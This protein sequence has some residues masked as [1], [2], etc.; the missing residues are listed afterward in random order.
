VSVTILVVDD[1]PQV[2]DWL[3][4]E[5]GR[6]GYTTTGCSDARAAVELAVREDFDLVVADVEMPGLR[7]IDLMSE[8]QARKPGTLVLLITAFGMVDLAV[9]AVKAGACDFVTKPF[10]IEVLLLAIERALRDRRMRKEIVRLRRLTVD[11]APDGIVARSPAMRRV[12]ERAER[13]AR[14]TSSVLLTGET[15][16]GKS[17]VA[18]MLHARSPRRA[19]PFVQVN[20]AG[21]PATLVEGELFGVRRGAFTGA[22]RDRDGL[23]ARAHGGTLLLDE[24]GELPLESQPKL[25][26][27]LETGRIRPLG[28]A[29]DRT[30]DVRLVAATNRDLQGAV[31]ER[32]FR[33]DLLFRLDVV[34][35]EVPPLRERKEDLEGLVDQFVERMSAR[36]GRAVLGVA[37]D[38]MA[39]LRAHSWPGNV[40]EL[41]NLVEQ[42]VALGEHDV[43][44]LDDVR[45]ESSD[46]AAPED[47]PLETAIASRTPLEAIEL[48]YIRRT[49]EACG[50][51]VSEA[52]RRLGID[53]RTLYRR[54]QEP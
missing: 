38:A 34:R 43:I 39:W 23:F 41:Q 26:D 52:A 27:V 46:P 5:L 51:N 6:E 21:I 47:D 35:I 16:V 30:V 49:L 42:A 22:D 33:A 14:V 37:E 4:D 9:R 50:G 45:R 28:G 29:P 12:L 3:R 25:L 7:G 20:C 8:I 48:A 53:R 54:L 10:T 11:D 44:T 17:T 2:V 1:H 40:R 19:G 15:G 32:T 31:R 36:V 24:V 18:R 13:A